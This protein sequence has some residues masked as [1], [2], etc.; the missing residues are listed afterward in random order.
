MYGLR[1][2]EPPNQLDG[3]LWEFKSIHFKVAKV[4]VL[5]HLF[6]AAW[7]ALKK[8]MTGFSVHF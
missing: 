3:E 2:L 5:C 6:L 4:E 8:M 1:L 7:R